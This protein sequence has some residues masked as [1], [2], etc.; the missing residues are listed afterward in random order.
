M[1][2]AALS[3]LSLSTYWTGGCY[4]ILIS[5]VTHALSVSHCACVQLTLVHEAELRV[6]S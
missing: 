4:I 5:L 1:S 3:A 2:F 6:W